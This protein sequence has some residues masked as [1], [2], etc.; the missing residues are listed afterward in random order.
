ME[1]SVVFSD[2]RIAKY[3][4]EGFWSEKTLDDFLDRMAG[5]YAEKEA[6]YDQRRRITFGELKTISDRLAL[7]F[8]E[9]GIGKGD[10]VFIQLPNW[11]EAVFAYYALFKIGAVGSPINPHYRKLDLQYLLGITEARAIIVPDHFRGFFYRELAEDL[12]LS[13]STLRYVLYVGKETID[14]SLSISE[15]AESDIEKRYPDGYLNAFKPKSS[16]AAELI[17]T[18][19]TTGNPKGVLHSHNA[20]VASCTFLPQEIMRVTQDDV[21][22]VLGAM[23]HQMGLVQGVFTAVTNGAKAV[24]LDV[25]D[26]ERAVELLET[27]RITHAIGVPTHIIEMLKAYDADKVRLHSLRRFQTA[28]ASCPVEVIKGLR[29]KM[30]CDVIVD[31]GM[32]ET[33]YTTMTRLDDP[34][35][36]I[37]E[38]VGRP[39]P[40]YE[41]KLLDDNQS[42]VSQGMIGEISSRTPELFMGYFKNLRAT[43]EIMTNDGFLLSGDLGLQDDYGNIRIVGRKKDVIIRGGEN[44]YPREIEDIL[45]MHPKILD[46]ALVGY[47]DARLGERSCAFIIP[48]PGGT[49]SLIEIQDFLKG[50]I[51]I[52][53]LPEKVKMVDEFPLTVSGKVKKNIL[54]RKLA[55]EIETK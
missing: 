48:E 19:G 12:K 24:L 54:R 3:Y 4:K 46:V 18:S 20:L 5:R 16:D 30:G 34:P 6:L 11:V 44:I 25:F 40:G 21:Y 9:L 39:F 2:E 35:E 28:G 51:A 8:L 38:T 36:I 45:L 52:Y 50:K 41:V 22:L 26:G 42:E 49:V 37:C 15:I 27:E 43:K 55:E 32:S 33:N 23:S 17:F 31:Y 29:E 14:D 47:P 53:K 10:I 7:K 13:V 1:S